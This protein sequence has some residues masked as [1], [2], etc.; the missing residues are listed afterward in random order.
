MINTNKNTQDYNSLSLLH[1]VEQPS[2]KIFMNESDVNEVCKIDY[3]EQDC[4][5]VLMNV[6]GLPYILDDLANRDLDNELPV[7]KESFVYR[8]NLDHCKKLQIS[9]KLFLKN[10]TIIEDEAFR[11]LL[12]E[13]SKLY[14]LERKKAD[15]L[16]K[17]YFPTTFERSRN[18]AKGEVVQFMMKNVNSG[19]MDRFKNIES[20][21]MKYEDSLNY[22][23]NGGPNDSVG[24]FRGGMISI[25]VPSNYTNLDEWQL[26]IVQVHELVH[27]ISNKSFAKIGIHLKNIPGSKHLNEAVTE[28][29]TFKIVSEHL[30]KGKTYI[31]NEDRRTSVAQSGYYNQIVSLKNVL[32]KVPFEFFKDA[33][34]NPDGLK[35]LELKFDQV[36]NG[37][38][39]FKDFAKKVSGYLH[40]LENGVEK[41]SAKVHHMSDYRTN[42]LRLSTNRGIK[43]VL[44]TTD[45]SS[46]ESTEN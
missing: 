22:I 16:E 28:I 36:F 21:Q 17:N 18:V 19:E 43:N 10:D 40:N 26:F 32:N 37:K 15:W 25:K 46:T 9:V 1:S 41:K 5:D 8:R 24:F 35:K 11:K 13:A 7:K 45:H 20:L 14:Y 38:Q 3:D 31:N 29:I 44:S 27:A 23:A 39:S 4:K 12:L 6:N 33:M 30:E 42:G 34:L 2:E